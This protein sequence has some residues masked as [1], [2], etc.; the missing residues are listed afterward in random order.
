MWLVRGEIWKDGE[1]L[2]YSSK[3]I[4]ATK[5]LPAKSIHRLLEMV[6]AEAR[7]QYVPIGSKRG[8]RS[9]KVFHEEQVDPLLGIDLPQATPAANAPTTGVAQERPKGKVGRPKDPKTAEVYAFC[10]ESR[11]ARK[12][13]LVILREAAIRFGPEAPKDIAAVS[14][15]IK[16]HSERNGLPL[17]G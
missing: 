16:R 13:L 14:K 17:P 5:S 7:H 8:G 12:K 6:G 1:G 4:A 15:Y 2:W 9:A 3:Y 11:A 10:Y